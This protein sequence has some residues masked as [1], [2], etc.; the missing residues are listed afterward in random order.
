M[1]NEATPL[2]VQYLYVHGEAEGFYYPTAR[3]AH[4]AAEVANRYLEC[5][6]TQ[7]ASLRLREVDC[8]LALV[9]NLGERGSLGRAGARLIAGLES[10]GVQILPTE[11]AHRPVDT[12]EHYESYVSSRYV[13]DAILAAGDGQPPDRQLWLTDLDCVW[14]DAERV[15]AA[16]PAEPEIGYVRIPYPPD[17]DVVGFGPRAGS[18]RQIG[19]LALEHGRVAGPARLGRRRAAE[20]HRRVAARDRVA[21]ARTSTSGSRP[22]ARCCRPRSRRSRSSARSGSRGSTTSRRSPAGS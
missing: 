14:I 5:A 11:Y 19:E 7:A 10:L 9:T 22:R 3:A 20:R 1:N 13:L 6:L 15:F 8:D 17:W 18:R 16:A 4:S 12:G 2:V 21:P